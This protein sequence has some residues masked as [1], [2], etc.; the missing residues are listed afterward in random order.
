MAV[1]LVRRAEFSIEDQQLVAIEVSD[2]KIELYQVDPADGIEMWAGY[3]SNPSI[4][5]AARIGAV[6][7][8]A[9]VQRREPDRVHRW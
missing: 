9:G 2:G 6:E 8:L 5:A 4:P 1:Y 3:I 7:A